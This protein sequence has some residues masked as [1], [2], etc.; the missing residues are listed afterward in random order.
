MNSIKIIFIVLILNVFNIT[1][2]FGQAWTQK[3]GSIYTQIGSSFIAG[4]SKY[5]NAGSP[6]DLVRKVTDITLQLYHEHGISDKLTIVGN[7]PFKLVSTG[8]EI[9]ALGFSGDTIPSGSLSGFG[10]I[11]LSAIYGLQQSGQWVYSLQLRTD[12]NTAKEKQESGLRTGVDAWGVAPSFHIG[13]GGNAFWSSF[14]LGGN[15]RSNNFS[16]QWFSNLQ[17]GKNINQ[18]FQIIGQLSALQSFEDGNAPD[19]KAIETGLYTNNLEYLAFSLKLGYRI[20]SNINLWGALGGGLSGNDVLRAPAYTISLS[21]KQS[22][23]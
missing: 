3:K 23:K 14:D 12:L 1:I 22:K 5:S 19:G 4:T 13:Y 8:D 21:F 16:T 9:V 11:S 15:F 10:N 18:K 7:V 20:T 6:L 17:L 2:S